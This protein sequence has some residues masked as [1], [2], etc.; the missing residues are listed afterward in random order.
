[1]SNEISL[2]LV[3]GVLANN[4]WC[5]SK[6]KNVIQ[7]KNTDEKEKK[8]KKWRMLWR[9]RSEPL[10]WSHHP[11][12]FSGQEKY[13]FL[14]LSG[15]NTMAPWRKGHVTLK[16]KAWYVKLSSYLVWCS[17][18]FCMSSMMHLVCHVTLQDHLPKV[19]SATVL[20]D[21]FICL[22]ESTW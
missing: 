7:P 6:K 18:D 3:R 1:M 2:I 11:A 16:V 17:S 12:K 15:Y 20:P 10:H 21:C 9:L 4:L 8:N 19:V 5:I 14:K 22:K 13:F